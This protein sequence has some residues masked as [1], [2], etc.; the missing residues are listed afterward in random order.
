MRRL[1]LVLP[2]FL[3]GCGT[4][5]STYW[6]HPNTGVIVECEASW[7]DGVKY[8]DVTAEHREYCERLMQRAGLVKM[9]RAEGKAA[10]R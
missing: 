2:V 5:D 1:L 8:Y 6:R 3:A 7:E 4:Y 10:L 9:D